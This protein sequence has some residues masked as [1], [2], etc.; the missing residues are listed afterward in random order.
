MDIGIY[1]FVSVL[2]CS[3]MPIFK[4]IS[5]LL[6]ALGTVE[7]GRFIA[8]RNAENAIPNAYIVVL[9]DQMSNQ[10][11]DSHINWVEELHQANIDR[12]D[13]SSRGGL[14][15][16]YDINGWKGYSGSFNQES[17]ERIL[18]NEN[19]YPL[20]ETMIPSMKY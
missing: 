12:G 18:E 9:K 20:S 3:K 6:V 13:E 2:E 1:Q 17:L 11:F 5:L 4:T 15:F 7:G 10:D 14:K 19:V 8:S 16:K